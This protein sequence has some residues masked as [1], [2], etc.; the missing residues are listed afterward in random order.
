[1]STEKTL[2][3]SALKEKGET[4]QGAAENL[5]VNAAAFRG[6]KGK[7]IRDSPCK[8]SPLDVFPHEFKTTATFT[9]AVEKEEVLLTKIKVRL[10]G[11]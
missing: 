7:N 3:A 5:T 10:Y 2:R 6:R 9:L 8:S 11:D 4:L 1:M